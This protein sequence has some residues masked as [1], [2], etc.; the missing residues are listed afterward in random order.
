MSR[1]G[2]IDLGGTKIQAVVVDDSEAVLGSSRRPTP[3]DGGPAGVVEAMAEA[4]GEACRS[5]GVA[6]GALAGVGVGSPGT[7]DESAGTVASAM[8]VLPDWKG[9]YPLGEEL[10]ARLGAPVRIGNDV[11]VATDAEFRLGA[12]RPYGSLLGVF[13]G[14][15]VGGGLVL[16]GHSWLGRGAAGEIGHLVVRRGGARCTCGRIG[17]MEAYAGRLAMERRARELS[18]RGKHTDLFKIMRQRDRTQ[19]SSGVWAHALEH[20]DKM[21][22]HLIGRALNALGAGIASAVNLL[23]V[24]AVV[25]GGGMG[26]RLGEPY[27][28][29]IEA[30]MGPHLFVDSRPPA[31][32]VAELGDLGGAI[33]AALLSSKKAA[34]TTA[35]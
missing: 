21:A 14:T 31:V 30:R 17:C 25:I 5:A 9:A 6:A 10:T 12:G 35:G 33:G 27:V 26:V 1:H 18:D 2:G 32:H 8:N 29:K 19:L 7:V 3:K 13:W 28:Q 22:H 15:G 11:R 24:E 16:D 4:L 34:V 20:G 23:D